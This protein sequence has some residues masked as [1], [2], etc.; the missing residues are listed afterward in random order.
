MTVHL[1]GKNG[2]LDQT[3]ENVEKVYTEGN[4]I[5]IN[6]YKGVYGNVSGVA[7]YK[8]EME[9]SEIIADI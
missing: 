9:I 8:D 6:Y 4:L 5:H 2:R 1:K 3:E 7:Y